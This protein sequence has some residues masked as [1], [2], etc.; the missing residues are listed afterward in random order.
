MNI[1]DI[2]RESAVIPVIVVDKPE[3]AVPLARALYAGGLRVLEVTLRTEAASAA[4]RAIREALPEAIVGAG[5]VLSAQDVQ[6]AQQVGAQVLVSPGATPALLDAMLL[7][8]L[9]MLPGVAS[10]SEAMAVYERG[11]RHMKLFPAEAIGGRALL[12][13]LAG[14]LP[15][16][17]F[18]PTGGIN[19]ELAADYLA[20]DN[21]LCVGGSWM[22]P[23]EAVAQGD[24]ARIEQLA[25]GA[26]ALAG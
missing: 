11:I 5:T 3:D 6:L 12:R 24:W 10:A 22:L 25:A 20:L 15:A 7:S 19:V 1:D 8:E 14:P 4:I 26:A 2:M 23:K 21:V 9:P 13:S 18:C 16:L 17:R